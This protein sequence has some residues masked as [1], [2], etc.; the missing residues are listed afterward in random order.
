MKDRPIPPLLQGEALHA[1]LQHAWSLWQT[2]HD[3]SGITRAEHRAAVA[4]YLH[5]RPLAPADLSELNQLYTLWMALDQPEAANAALHQHRTTVLSAAN[6]GRADPLH[7]DLMELES[8][9]HRGPG[10]S[11]ERLAAIAAQ[12][13]ADP[14]LY[15]ALDSQ[16]GE[17]AWRYQALEAHFQWRRRQPH[18]GDEPEA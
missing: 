3:D 4:E 9:R 16:W 2:D 7:W 6:A 13:Q 8:R 17:T 1:R 14:A 15:R 5:Q 12:M 18:E 11:S 10:D